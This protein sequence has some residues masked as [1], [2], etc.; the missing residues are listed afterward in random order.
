[1]AC[2]DSRFRVR[3]VDG[4]RVV[5]RFEV[6]A[7]SGLVSHVPGSF[8]MFRAR[9]PCSG[10]VSHVP[11]S[12]PM[13]PIYIISEKA[14]DVILEDIVLEDDVL[15]DGVLLE[16]D[17]ATRVEEELPDHGYANGEGRKRKRVGESNGSGER[18]SKRG[19]R[20]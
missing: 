18:R 12:F 4:L 20:Y 14:T 16:D 6:S 17:E 3:G 5:G 2:L 19:S 7:C 10:L 9:F 13:L 1:M 15:V 11:G 8:P